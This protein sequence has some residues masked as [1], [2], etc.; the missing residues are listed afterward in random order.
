MVFTKS[1]TFNSFLR[2]LGFWKDACDVKIGFG[3]DSLDALILVLLP[4]FK[5]SVFLAD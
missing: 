2:I 5:L 3:T 4:F 1:C